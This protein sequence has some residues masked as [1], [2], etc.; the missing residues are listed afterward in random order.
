MA[1]AV[2]I[3]NPLRVRLLTEEPDY[4]EYLTTGTPVDNVKLGKHK[5]ARRLPDFDTFRGLIMVQMQLLI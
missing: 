3:Q 5:L 4:K 1:H 2:T